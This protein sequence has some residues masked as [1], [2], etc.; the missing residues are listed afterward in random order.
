MVNFIPT[1]L[2]NVF[3]NAYID[4]THNTN[5]IICILRLSKNAPFNVDGNHPAKIE[6]HTLPIP[7]LGLPFNTLLDPSGMFQQISTE[8]S[9]NIRKLCGNLI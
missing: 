8:N 4:F 1:F 2:I 6:K 5:E 7:P 3:K 9:G